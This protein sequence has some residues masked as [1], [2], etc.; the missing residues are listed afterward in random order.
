MDDFLNNILKTEGVMYSFYTDTDSCYITLKGLVDK[1]FS[2]KSHSELIDILDKVGSEQ[3]EPC[4][5]KAMSSL[6]QYTNAFEEKIFFKREAIADKCLWVAKKRY[7]MNVWDNEG[8]RYEKPDL[9]VLGLEIVRSSTPRPVRDSLREAVRICLTQDEK[10]L[11]KFI[12]DTRKAFNAMTPEEIAFPRSSNNMLKY[13]DVNSI[14]DKGCPMHVRGSLLYNNYLEVFKVSNR[15]EKIQEGDKIKF[16]YL[17]EPNTFRENTIAFK[18]KLPEEFGVHKYVDYNLMFQK[19]FIE[20]MDT[21]VKT[22]GWH[23]EKQ[24]TLEDLFI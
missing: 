13:S 19:A 9:K 7:A 17:K 24:S 6:A 11:H 2:K 18:G 5:N 20:P 16:I 1:F 12:E 21:I 3:I 15:Y 23:T 22:L 4:I 14:Y 10:I 8:V